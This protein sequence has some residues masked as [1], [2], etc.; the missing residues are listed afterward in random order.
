MAY[1]LSEVVRELD[2][3]AKEATGCAKVHVGAAL[4]ELCAGEGLRVLLKAANECLPNTCRTLGCNRMRLY[5]DDS[6]NHRLP[7]DCNAIHSEQNLICKA[8]SEGYTLEGRIVLVTRYPCETCARMLIKSNVAVVYY[9]RS[10][11]PSDITVRMF[12]EANIPLIHIVELD[13][14]DSQDR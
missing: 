1:T 4:L 8:N 9:C 7:S 12:E 11:P 3:Y 2:N 6:K 13:N 14:E 5:G 10:T